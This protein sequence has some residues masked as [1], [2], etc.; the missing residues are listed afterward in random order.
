MHRGTSLSAMRIP[1][2]GAEG[3]ELGSGRSCITRV[4]AGSRQN[5]KW[6]LKF[7][8]KNGLAACVVLPGGATLGRVWEGTCDDDKCIQGDFFFFLFPHIIL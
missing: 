5:E 7:L 8:E 3:W 2:A 6:H 4:P 1:G